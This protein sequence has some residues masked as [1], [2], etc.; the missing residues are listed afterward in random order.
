MR[1]VVGCVCSRE[2]RTGGGLLECFECAFTSISRGN[3]IVDNVI[4]K[5]KGCTTT[6]YK[7]F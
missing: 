5:E 4:R 6:T 1:W 2:E 7:S 3:E